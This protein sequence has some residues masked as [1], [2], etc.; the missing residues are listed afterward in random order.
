MDDNK[1]SHV[2][3]N[4]DTTIVE[5]IESKIGKLKRTTDKTHKFLGMNIKFLGTRKV[6]ITSP[7]HIKEAIE[8]SKGEVKKC[9]KTPK[10]IHCSGYTLNHNLWIN[11]KTE[12]F[13]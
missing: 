12:R 6:A 10:N 7:Q 8:H 4:V 3:D 2:N 9:S 11:K 13:H 5:I 1:I